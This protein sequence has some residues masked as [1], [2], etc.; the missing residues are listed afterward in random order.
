[1]RRYR[2]EF[3]DRDSQLPAD[4]RARGAV[5]TAIG[6]TAR[7]SMQTAPKGSPIADYTVRSTYD[8]RPIQ[9]T[10][11]NWYISGTAHYAAETPTPTLA[12][13][14]SVPQGYV[15]VLKKVHWWIDTPLILT[16]RAQVAIALQV[17]GGN[18]LGNE[19]IPVGNEAD[20]DTFI[21]ADEFSRLGLLATSTAWLS[22]GTPIAA[23]LYGNLLQKTGR[24]ATF[25]IANL[26]SPQN[27]APFVSGS[28][29]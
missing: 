27:A 17:N 14:Y 6:T 3:I 19:F 11:F 8:S 1:M 13:A 10:D 20:I 7:G 16:S 4:A 29:E 22:G 9:G 12:L 2:G 28:G 25:E 21:I 15:A 24:P 5:D 23:I 18:Q 26:G